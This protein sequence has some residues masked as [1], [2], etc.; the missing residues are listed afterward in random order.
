MNKKA[1]VTITTILTMITLMFVYIDYT[2]GRLFNLTLITVCVFDAILIFCVLTMFFENTK[3]ERWIYKKWDQ[4]EFE[5]QQVIR[6]LVLII[7]FIT[8]AV[9]VYVLFDLISVGS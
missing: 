1:M 8:L 4:I 3:I 5:N 6:T 2:H 7:F 9:V